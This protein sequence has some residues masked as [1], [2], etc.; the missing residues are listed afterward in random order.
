[1]LIGEGP[2]EAEYRAQAQRLEIADRVHF[3]GLVPETLPW[4]R[5][6]DIVCVPSLKDS[7]P[8]TT[9]EAMSMARPIIASRAGDLP[10]AI[11]DGRDGLLVEVGSTFCA[12]GGGRTPCL[13]P[14]AA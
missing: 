9:L 2:A 13:L 12:R 7:L 11:T 4:L 5:A 10:L 6:M 14:G 3:A 1:M 8:L